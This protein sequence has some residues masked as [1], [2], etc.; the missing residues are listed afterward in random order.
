M[1]A[2]TQTIDSHL[3]QTAIL[4]PFQA[5]L[6]RINRKLAHEGCKVVTANNAFAG[7]EWHLVSLANGTRRHTFL[8]HMDI[9]QKARDLGLVGKEEAVLVSNRS[10]LE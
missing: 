7:K 4:L 5:V 10:V 9:V 8:T 3:E 1:D 2:I 6:K